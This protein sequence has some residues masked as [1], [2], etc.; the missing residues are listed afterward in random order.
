MKSQLLPSSSEI[1]RLN[2][3]GYK[4]ISDAVDAF[5]KETSDEVVEYLESMLYEWYQYY[6]QDRYQ[7]E[8][9]DKFVNVMFRV[10]DLLL[11]LQDAHHTLKD[12]NGVD[13]DPLKLLDYK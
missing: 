13:R 12:N 8:H 5:F 9:I 11:R 7:V 3:E 6:A 10:N 4:M 1:C 2:P